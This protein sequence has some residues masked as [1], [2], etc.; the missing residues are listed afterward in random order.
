[1]GLEEEL[2]KKK[3]VK[4]PFILSAIALPSGLGTYL[5]EPIK[6]FTGN[7]GIDEYLGIAIIGF[8]VASSIYGF[9]KLIQNKSRKDD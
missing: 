3:S 1:M 4:V 7:S 2:N 8:G 9:Y 5:Y 6:S